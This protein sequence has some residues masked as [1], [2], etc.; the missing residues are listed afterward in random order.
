ML[1]DFTVA[2]FRSIKDQ[3]NFTMLPSGRIK[4]TDHQESLISIPNQRF[5]LVKSTLIYGGNASGKSNFLTAFAALIYLVKNSAD[6]KLDEKIA[7]YE[8]FRLDTETIKMPVEFDIHFLSKD[9]IRYKYSIKYNSKEILEENLYFFPQG[10]K[11]KIFERN[12]KIEYGDRFTGKKRYD[13]LPNQLFLSKAGVEPIE[14]LKPAYRFFSLY[15]FSSIIHDTDYDQALI[16]SFTNIIAQGKD[17][18]IAEN[19]NKLLCA[20]DSGINSIEIKELEAEDFKLPAELS[21]KERKRIVEKYKYTIKTK[22]KLY[23]NE[24]EAG[25]ESFD[26]SEESTGTIKLLAVGGLILEALEEGQTI[27]IDELD[28][29]LHPLLTRMLIQIFNTKAN[30]PNNS[31]LI[32]ATHDISLID[33]MLLRRDQIWLTEKNNRGVS[34]LFPLSDFTGISKVRTL[35]TWYINGRFGGIPSLKHHLLNLEFKNEENTSHKN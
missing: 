20:S 34:E 6:F 24:K 12:S 32:F 9:L 19:I 14:I 29:S 15:I 31:Q 2:N 5:N 22:H 33:S 28:K 27:I 23:T 35:N 7:A 13:L 25:L 1:I 17:S 26:L 16:N 3:I 8:P 30:N 10:Q 11:S 21:E 18:L 4:E